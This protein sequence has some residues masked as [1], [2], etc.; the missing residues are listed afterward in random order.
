MHPPNFEQELSSVILI[1]LAGGALEGSLTVSHGDLGLVIF[2]HGSGSSRHS[3][4]NKLV[5][6]ALNRSGMSTLLFDLLTEDESTDRNLVFDIELLATRVETTI[7]F[8][9]PDYITPN[10][11]IGLFGAS[12]GAAAA[13]EVAAK[14]PDKI[15]A[16]VS[17]GGRPDLADRYLSRVCA[18]T[19][20]IVGSADSEVLQLNCEAYED[21][22]CQKEL[23]IVRGATHLF[24][25][26]GT[27]EKVA[28]VAS[29]WFRRHLIEA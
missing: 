27:L 15:N 28:S 7:N 12:T 2:V 26:A 19:L 25:E 23:F 6:R 22:R 14:L 24:E 16:V 10:T 21:L 13:L 8:L 5:A 18:P 20:L 3:P 11:R 29:D 9:A 17:R 1:P 4:R